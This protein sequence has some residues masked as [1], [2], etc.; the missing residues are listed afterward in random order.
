MRESV[1][2][3]FI[4]SHKKAALFLAAGILAIFFLSPNLQRRPM[5]IVE[6]PAVFLLSWVHKGVFILTSSLKGLWTGYIALRGLHDENVRLSKEIQRLKGEV[7][8]L[9][10]EETEA[11]RLKRLLQFKESSPYKMTA[12]AVIGREPTSWYKTFLLDKGENDGVNLH[13]GVI[14]PSGVVGKVVKIFPRFSHVQLLTDRNS[15]IAAIDQRSR[16]QG[17]VEGTEG[18]LLRMKYVD[19]EAD[20]QQGDVI[21]TSGTDRIFPKGLFI[22]QVSRVERIEGEFFLK[23]EVTPEQDLSDPEEVFVLTTNQ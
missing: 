14:V 23:I 12:A 15:A 16:E 22:G 18:D 13:M 8:S 1:M 21:L 5:Q 19:S 4:L 20:V 2:L 9:K 7:I 11:Q 6:R 10:E 17:I 3:R